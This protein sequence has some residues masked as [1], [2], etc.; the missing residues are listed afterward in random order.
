MSGNQNVQMVW[1]LIAY[2]FCCSS[3]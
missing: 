2:C 1:T 3:P